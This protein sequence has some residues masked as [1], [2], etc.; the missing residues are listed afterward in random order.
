MTEPLTKPGEKLQIVPE[1][2][3]TFI[4]TISKTFYGLEH[5]VIADYIQRNVC[6]NEERLRQFLKF[7]PK[8]LKPILVALKVDKIIKERI[9]TE[10]I[11]GRQRKIP[12]YFINYKGAVNVTKYKLDQIRHRLEAQEQTKSNRTLFHCSN[13]GRQYDQ[14]DVGKLFQPETGKMNCWSCFYEVQAEE[15]AGPSE[16]TR[17]SLAKFNEQ[18]GPL[19]SIMQQ[20]NGV[21][22]AEHILEPPIP[23]T[24]E[25]TEKKEEPKNVISLGARFFNPNEPKFTADTMKLNLGEEMEFAEPEKE[26]VPWLTGSVRVSIADEERKAA[27][28]KSR[29][30]KKSSARIRKYGM[31]HTDENEEIEQL[32]EKEKEVKKDG[33]ITT[34]KPTFEELIEQIA[35]LGLN[36]FSGAP[37][38]KR[39]R[40]TLGDDEDDE[41]PVKPLLKKHLTHKQALREE[42]MI[43]YGDILIPV[44]EVTDEM[45]EKMSKEE[46][47][48]VC[49]ARE[50]LLDL[51]FRCGW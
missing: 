46:L 28:K 49:E 36:G 15:N 51:L 32:L 29:E 27:A 19:V 7:D 50:K 23:T 38:A 10:E 25:E 2:L 14:L 26:A 41:K 5:F 11:Q 37:L 13:C 24:V 22:F 35:D 3:K 18:T 21:I 47:E 40:F 4:L 8:T 6:V 20:M 12:Y 9:V 16:D 17:S 39:P 33:K 31:D 45:L 1:F 44:N 42:L 30:I 43:S 34:K 48:K